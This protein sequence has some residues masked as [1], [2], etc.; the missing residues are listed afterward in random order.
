MQA[1]RLTQTPDAG[2]HRVEIAIEVPG[3]ARRTAGVQV[4]F[5]VAAEDKELIRWYLEDYPEGPADVATQMLAGQAAELMGDLGEQLFRVLFGR[6][7]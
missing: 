1:L 2:G 3:R 7:R 4:A 5:G 6:G